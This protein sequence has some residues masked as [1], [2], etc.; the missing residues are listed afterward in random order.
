ME[1]YSR[2][3]RPGS[4]Q[5]GAVVTLDIEKPAAGGRMLARHD[6]QVVLVAGAIPGERVRARLDRTARGVLY[7]ETM[8]VL[9]ASPDRRPSPSDPRCGGHALAHIE[10]PRQLQL[11]SEIV[12]D[13]FRRIA[14]LPLPQAPQVLGSPQAGYRMRARL[15]AANGRFGFFREG[16][17]QLCDP[18]TTG[19][20]ADATMKWIRQAEGSV[21]VRGAGLHTLEVAEDV[22]GR[23]RVCHLELAAGTR[24]EPFA[25]LAAGLEG[26]SARAGEGDVVHLAGAPLVSDV[27]HARPGDHASA[28]RLRRSARAFFQSNRFLLEPLVHHVVARVPPGPVIDL[29]AGVG[30]FGLALAAAGF[31]D[32]TLV[33]GDPVA[34]DDLRGNAE[35]FGGRVRVEHS[36]VESFLAGGGPASRG[37]PA[38]AAPGRGGGPVSSG[39]R[40]SAGPL[41]LIVDPPRTG[42]SKE[43][44]S[45]IAGLR[46]SR[47][48]YVSCDVATLA[49]DA[50][51]LVDAGYQLG[52]LTGMDVFP[53]TA[54]IET[55]TVFDSAPVIDRSGPGRHP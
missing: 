10:Y 53:N 44:L 4:V 25:E 13:A 11:K 20:L 45:G 39:G 46:P 55:I 2:P 28:F 27:L 23:A 42:L 47:L 34:G 38:S 16:S 37:D 49:R 24:L 50:R 35:A 5:T 12:V 18:G 43:A 31:D 7:A 40:A 41:T 30:V 6:G 32:V 29:Y 15:H 22:A 8:D 36:S 54:H 17:H 3:K 14:R 48:L 51:A 52:G 1:P 9:T 19:Q 33:E 26:L 21:A